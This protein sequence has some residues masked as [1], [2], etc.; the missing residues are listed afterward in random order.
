M[1]ETHKSEHFEPL[2]VI[3]LIHLP[4]MFSKRKCVRWSHIQLR[5]HQNRTEAHR[6]KYNNNKIWLQHK[7]RKCACHQT[8]EFNSKLKWVETCECSFFF[9]FPC[10]CEFVHMNLCDWL[11]EYIL[12]WEKKIFLFYGIFFYEF[13]TWENLSRER[14]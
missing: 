1:D 4:F 7:N 8:H 12:W 10:V 14:W 5:S 9:F 2:T 11:D 6:Q 13:I 3:F